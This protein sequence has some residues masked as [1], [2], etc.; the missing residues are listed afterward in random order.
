MSD[1]FIRVKGKDFCLNDKKII[2][3]GYGIGTWLNLEHFMIGIPGTDSQIRTAIAN[4]YGK[5]KAKEFWKKFYKSMVDE[6]DFEFLNGLGIN[7]IRIPFNYR[8]FE[9]DQEPYSYMEEGFEEIDRVLRLCEQ[10][11][12]YAVLDLHAAVGGQNP[13][14]HSDNAIG[15]SLFWEYAD[16]R[17]RTISLWKYIANRYSSNRWVA[18]Y[19]LLNEP[20]LLIRDKKIANQFFE[21]LI[22]EIRKVDSNHLLFV[23]GDM[24]A[25]RF[26]LFEPFEDPNVACSFHF[27]PFLHQRLYT[28]QN[29]KEEIEH[30]LFENVS[31]RDI[32][33]RLKRPV[34]CG[35]TGALYNCGDRARHEGMLRDVL[36][37][38]EKHGIS[39]SVWTYK[40][41]RSMGTVHPKEDSEWV[42]FSKL[43]KQ[44]WDFWEEFKS[45]GKYVEELIGK[46]SADVSE[47]EKQK[48]GFRVLAN[49]QLVLKEAYSKIFKDIP[50]ELFLSYVNSFNYNNCEVWD[51]VV[52]IVTS[53]TKSQK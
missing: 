47:L 8:L 14:W 28:K 13:D 35:E 20:V 17:K 24:Y 51:G 1:G 29:Q 42:C 30:V 38:Y 45:R 37:I 52:N 18:A 4:A 11:E 22:G 2:L 34:W 46:Y 19:D 7:T 25:T 48:I 31:L 10:Y 50:F 21:D 53:H 15:E 3:R 41:A 33:E 6:S 36:E 26:E 44:K 32:F 43:A 39:W 16:F 23:Q 40:D 12:L 49:Y 9:N 5:K 27:Y